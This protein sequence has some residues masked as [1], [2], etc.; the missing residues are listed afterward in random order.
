MGHINSGNNNYTI[1]TTSC[2][3][4]TTS[5]YID[6]QGDSMTEYI[7]F[8]AEILGIDINYEKFKKMSD[9][10]KKSFLRDIK[11]NNILK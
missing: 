9:C 1:T 2:G 6:F 7:D 11:I 10:E 4:T 8:I 3:T 5:G